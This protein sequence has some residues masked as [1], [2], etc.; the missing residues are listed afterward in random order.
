MQAAMAMRMLPMNASAQ[1]DAKAPYD[2]ECA[3]KLRAISG[4]GVG[5]LRGGVLRDG[6]WRRWSGKDG[7]GGIHGW[8]HW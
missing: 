2:H 5:D 7:G 1:G 6:D 4:G 8:W 3:M